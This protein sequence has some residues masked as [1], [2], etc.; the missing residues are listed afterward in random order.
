ME[1]T[2]YIQESKMIPV[3]KKQALTGH[4]H[5]R[6]HYNIRYYPIIIECDGGSGS[7]SDPFIIEN[8]IVFK[9]IEFQLNSFKIIEQSN[10]FFKNIEIDFIDISDSSNI[11][12]ED[13]IFNDVCVYSQCSDISCKNNNYKKKLAIE[14]T[15]QCLITESNIKF[16]RILASE[17]NLFKKCQIKQLYAFKDSLNNAF[18]HL[19]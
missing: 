10:I 14:N 18:E 6:L 15:H 11:T 5:L 9:D 4:V 12:L 19:E 16:L 13:C 17:N 8:S 7:S 3:L 1:L 2:V